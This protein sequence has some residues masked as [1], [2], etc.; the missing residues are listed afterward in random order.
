MATQRFKEK[1]VDGQMLFDNVAPR[2]TDLPQL[3]AD[4]TALGT[5]LT[6][7]RELQGQQ[8]LAKGHLR[9]LNKR[10][11]EVAEQTADLRRR[12]SAALKASLG[13]E[14]T[15]LLEFG[16]RPRPTTQRRRV[17]LTPAQKA[18]RAVQRAA[19]K[20]AE[21]AAK[22]QAAKLSPPAPEPPAH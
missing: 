6:Q 3:A 7:A 16:I 13:P 15:S 17:I 14:S 18:A 9:E 4:H 21:L 20:A 22:E 2:L 5:A 12:L 8:E 1:I 11:Q 19:A 10:R